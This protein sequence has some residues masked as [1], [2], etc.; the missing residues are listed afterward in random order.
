[1]VYDVA[2]QVPG[3]REPNLSDT[4]DDIVAQET[5]AWMSVSYECWVTPSPSGETWE[6][7]RS[8]PT[9]R[10]FEAPQG[11]LSTRNA[12][13]EDAF[14]RGADAVVTWDADAPPVHDHVLV[15]MVDPIERGA[16]ASM[17]VPKSPP[18]VTGIAVNASVSVLQ[19]V[20]P[21]IHGQCS[22]ISR[23]GWGHAGPFDDSVDQTV[24]TQVWFEEERGFYRRLRE[25]GEVVRVSDATVVNDLRRYACL[26]SMK[27][28]TDVPEFCDRVDGDVTFSPRGD[29]EW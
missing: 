9:F 22:A 23:E 21:Y 18:T 10:A 11:K 24:P 28:F 5:P 12:A 8:H 20:F 6:Q 15:G 26:F 14:S 29:R 16:V 1:M 27:G 3:Y 19:S 17:A 4:L 7:A 13:H 2:V 25:V